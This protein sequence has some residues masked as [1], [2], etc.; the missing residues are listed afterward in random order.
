MAALFAAD[1]N[2]PCRN[3]LLNYK[4]L[5]KITLIA[6]AGSVYRLHIT[7][8]TKHIKFFTFFA[9]AV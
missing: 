4:K 7:A 6:T 8:L 1:E 5:L 2:F 9:K 3:F